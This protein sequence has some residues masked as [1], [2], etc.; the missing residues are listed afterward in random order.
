[1]LGGLSDFKEKRILSLS[2]DDEHRVKMVGVQGEFG[3][4]MVNESLRLHL[5]CAAW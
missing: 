1:M 5:L 4:S 2:L 3:E